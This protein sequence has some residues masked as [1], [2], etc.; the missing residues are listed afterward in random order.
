VQNIK[1][2]FKIAYDHLVLNVNP[3]LLPFAPEGG[4]YDVNLYEKKLG[5]VGS[6]LPMNEVVNTRIRLNPDSIWKLPE[7]EPF[8]KYSEFQPMH[9]TKCGIEFRDIILPDALK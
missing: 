2:A 6:T 4:E 9:N 5:F 8:F 3:D 1:K 7:E